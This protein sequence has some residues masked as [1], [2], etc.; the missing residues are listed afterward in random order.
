MRRKRRKGHQAGVQSQMKAIFIN[1][2][3]QTVSMIE[4][5]NDLQAMYDKIRCLLVHDQNDSLAF[6]AMQSLFRGNAQHISDFRD[7]VFGA[8]NHQTI[9]FQNLS[10]A[11][12][13][14]VS[15]FTPDQ[16]NQRTFRKPQLGQSHSVE[17]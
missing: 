6:A 14:D 2:K 5:E 13:N 8:E 4:V 10:V 11:M 9:I 7:D 17:F 12:R 3:N 16:Q 15:S 1:A